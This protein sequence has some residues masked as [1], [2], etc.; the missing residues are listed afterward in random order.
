MTA[1]LFES[2]AGVPVGP[3]MQ[4]FKEQFRPKYFAPEKVAIEKDEEYFRT[5]DQTKPIEIVF[6]VL[7][8]YHGKIPIGCGTGGDRKIARKT[9]EVIG[10]LHLV[11]AIVTCD[12][13]VNG[14]PAPD[15]FLKCAE[16]LGVEPQ[17]C[18]VFEDGQPGIEAA[19]AAGMMVTDVRNFL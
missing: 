15:T 3:Q 7:K 5:I 10:A 19:K 16:L 14:K 8:K 17:Y 9:L 13:V 6:D 1:N 12:D 4:M 11:D 2:M 18:Q